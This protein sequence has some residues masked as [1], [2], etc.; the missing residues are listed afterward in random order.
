MLSLDLHHQRN[1]SELINAQREARDT[2]VIFVTHDVNPILPYVDRV[3]YLAGG[4]FRMGTPD[5]VLRS[6]VL[7]AMYG[8]PVEVIRSHGRVAVLGTPDSFGGGHD[9]IG[10]HAEHA[11]H[12]GSVA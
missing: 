3:L 7:T 1:V 8:T 6:D 11:E 12:A 2:A 5:E 10:D 4:K 9:P